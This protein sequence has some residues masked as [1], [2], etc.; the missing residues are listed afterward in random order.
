M[1]QVIKQGMVAITK[2]RFDE[3]FE[4]LPDV[5]YRSERFTNRPGCSSPKGERFYD[6]QTGK[7]VIEMDD[8][9]YPR[10]MIIRVNSE[11]F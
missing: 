7:L 6:K 3:V 10:R 9:D 11:Y 4:R 5:D 1:K 8:N 2:K